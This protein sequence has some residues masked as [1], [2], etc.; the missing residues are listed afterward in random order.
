[1]GVTLYRYRWGVMA[2]SQSSSEHDIA[3]ISTRSLA[4]NNIV[5][6]QIQKILWRG[7]LSS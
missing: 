1:M 6:F 7:F 2:Q 3:A 4:I 5:H